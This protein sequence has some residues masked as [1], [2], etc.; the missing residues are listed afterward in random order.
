MSRPDSRIN[1][2]L[3]ST[4]DA[5]CLPKAPLLTPGVRQRLRDVLSALFQTKEDVSDAIDDPVLKDSNNR[6][7]RPFEV[8]K[9]LG[10]IGTFTPPVAFDSNYVHLVALAAGPGAPQ[11]CLGNN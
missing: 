10:S 6:Q 7:E 3:W 2:L 8:L 1:N 9:R 11:P 4:P 5:I